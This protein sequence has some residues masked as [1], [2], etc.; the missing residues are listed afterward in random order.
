VKREN[1]VEEKVRRGMGMAIRY[2]ER[3]GG[4]VMGVRMEISGS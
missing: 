3:R 1:S 4:R 2:G